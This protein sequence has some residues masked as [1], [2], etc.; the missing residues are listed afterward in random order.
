MRATPEATAG[1]N[2]ASRG[3]RAE[4][5]QPERRDVRVAHMPAIEV[6]VGE[7]EHDQ[8]GGEDR[9]ARRA[10]DALRVGGQIEHL[11]PESEVRAD[12]G[13]HRPAERRGGGK[14]HA[15]LHDEQDGEEQREQTGNADDDAVV[16]R[17]RVDLVLVGVRLPQIELRQPVG[18]KLDHVGDDRAG[19]ERD[20]VDVGR[21]IGLAIGPVAGARRH[22]DDARQPEVGPE[23]AGADHA[24]V[25][26]DDQPVDLL[27]AVVGEREHRPVV[28]GLARAHLDAADDAV[29]AGRGR[30]LDAIAFGLRALDRVGEIDRGGVDAH[31]DRLDRARA[32]NAKRDAEQD[33]NRK[34][35][36]LETQTR[37]LR[38]SAIPPVREGLDD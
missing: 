30:D 16:E 36:A 7:Q 4:K 37:N 29:R 23:Q 3:E 25:R 14:H 20:A 24:V 38:L 5:H 31:V 12:I 15:A 21:R 11:A 18:A 6:E 28:A 1:L 27:V 22:V 17:E 9:F 33:R 26:H 35:G 2:T 34:H 32:I 13:E 10:P 19:I 8:R